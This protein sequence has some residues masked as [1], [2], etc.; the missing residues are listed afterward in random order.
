MPEIG[1]YNSVIMADIASI[2]GQTVPAGGGG[3]TASTTGLL[4]WGYDSAPTEPI[5]AELFPAA[6]TPFSYQVWTGSSYPV[7]KMDFTRYGA[8]ILDTNGDLYTAAVGTS[9]NYIGRNSSTGTSTSFQLARTGV[10]DM[11]VSIQGCITIESGEMY[12]TGANMRYYLGVTT[13]SYQTWTQFGTDTDWI[14]VTSV[15][16]YPYGIAAVKGPTATTGKLYVSGYHVNGRLGNG[17]TGGTTQTPTLSKIDA[18]T[19]FEEYVAH[20]SFGGYNIGVVTQSGE[21][22]ACGWGNYGNAGSG[23][24]SNVTYMTQ[25]GTDTDWE[26]SFMGVLGGFAIKGG[27][28]YASSSS[29]AYQYSYSGMTA[30]RTYQLI[31][32]DTDWE[33][34]E[35]FR[36]QATYDSDFRGCLFKKNGEWGIRGGND[37]WNG[38][39]SSS[40][41]GNAFTSFKDATNI[42]NAV[43]AS[44]TIDYGAVIYNQM[45]ASQ[46]KLGIVLHVR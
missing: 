4:V 20:V 28:L 29:T 30:N 27:Q 31:N 22:Y 17:L 44:R 41:T 12:F 34:I 25:V 16:T 10:D 14:S 21:F 32:S 18:T 33:E 23:S 24:S 13:A 9:Y 45:N 40:A 19:D 11:S 37:G 2:N 3:Y 15:G 42:T 6:E 36:Y 7:K 43:G 26:K 1:S 46:Q 5:P 8:Y 38:T 39:K 35:G